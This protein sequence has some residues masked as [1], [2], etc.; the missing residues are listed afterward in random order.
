MESIEGRIPRSS[1]WSP[2]SGDAKRE[3]R[4]S[5]KLAHTKEC[6][7]GVEIPGI[8]QLLQTLHQGLFQDCYSLASTSQKGREME[9]EEKA[10]GSILKVERGV[11]N[12]PSQTWIRK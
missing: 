6:Q 4:R 7:E 5:P 11:Y 8:S 2:R 1:N 10:R 9:M 12:R 3:G